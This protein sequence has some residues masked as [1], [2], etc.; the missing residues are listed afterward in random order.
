MTPAE[1]KGAIRILEALIEIANEE[2][3]NSIPLQDVERLYEKYTK[4]LGEE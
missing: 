1:L 2:Q 3:M 4:E